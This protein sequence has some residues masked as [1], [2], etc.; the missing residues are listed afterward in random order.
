MGF[1]ETDWQLEICSAID[2]VVPF[3]GKSQYRIVVNTESGYGNHNTG[4]NIDS[5]A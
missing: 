4:D 5:C 1:Y 3:S 2:N